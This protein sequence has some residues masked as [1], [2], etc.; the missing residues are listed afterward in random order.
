MNDLNSPN[1]SEDLSTQVAA[2]RRQVLTLLLALI[3]VSGTLTV[4]LYRQSSILGYDIAGIKPQAVQVIT[5]FN[6]NRAGMEVFM[7]QL[8][9]Y[10]VAHP[11]FQPV[12][13]KYGWVPP[14]TPAPVKK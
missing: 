14:A 9:A 3:V 10:A 7:Q 2:L 4:F 8:S 6:Q 1:P 12:L 5:T 11:E 13:K